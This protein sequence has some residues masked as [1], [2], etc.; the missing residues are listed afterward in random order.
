MESEM[1]TVSFFIDCIILGGVIAILY[2][3]RK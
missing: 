2:T 1:V 3:L